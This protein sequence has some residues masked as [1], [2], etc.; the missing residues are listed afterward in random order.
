MEGNLSKARTSLLIGPKTSPTLG[1]FKQVG[2]LYR[3]ISQGGDRRLVQGSN[4]RKSRPLYSPTNGTSPVHVRNLSETSVPSGSVNH[5]KH[6]EVRSASAMEYGRGG[7]SIDS[8]LDERSKPAFTK[9]HSTASNRSQSSPLTVLQEE[10]GSASTDFASPES[11]E[12]TGLAIRVDKSRYFTNDC[13]YGLTRSQSQMS[14]RELRDQLNGLKNKIADLRTGQRAE[15]SRRNSLQNLRTPNSFTEAEEWYAG[16]AEYKSGVS[17]LS[18]NAGMGLRSN[19]DVENAFPKSPTP[20]RSPKLPR[21][22]KSPSSP[23]SPRSPSFAKTMAIDDSQS[24]V[25]PTAYFGQD[26]HSYSST[27]NPP[28]TLRAVDRDRDDQDSYIQDSLYEDAFEERS[29]E[30]DNSVAAS[31]E[32]QIYLNEVLEESLQDAEPEV[33]SIPGVYQPVEPE[34]HEDRADAFDYENFFLHSA[35]GN[36][37]QAGLHRRNISQATA[38]SRMSYE[39]SDSVETTR[40]PRTEE[41]EARFDVEGKEENVAGGERMND[42]TFIEEEEEEEEEEPPTP[43]GPQAPFAQHFRSNSTESVSSTATFATATEGDNDSRAE[44]DTV[45]SEILRWGERPSPSMVGAWPSPPA[46]MPLGVVNLT[47]GH[48]SPLS[49]N[50]LS[51]ETLTP[52]SVGPPPTPPAS[53]PLQ[54]QEEDLPEEEEEISDSSS[55]Q[56]PANTEILISALITLANPDFKPTGAF[57]EVDKDLVVNVLRSVGAV[58]EGINASDSRGDV[59]ESRIWRRRLDVARRVLEG[60]IEV[61][62]E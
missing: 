60:E 2:G 32:E 25:V 27:P 14:T 49:M 44:S 19:K 61:E 5:S 7:R 50:V 20:P 21:S 34:R 51:A 11:S 39:S 37:S 29:D 6:P 12:N 35:L 23:R 15:R 48:T 52:H 42:S 58:C 40:A 28:P 59:Y 33:P 36:Y 26:L 22:P 24:G 30:V 45:P 62:D 47:N 10:E 1:D 55:H 13:G 38:E 43:T 9:D 3:S 31:Q 46:S 53:S 4:L 56:H 8:L 18:T 54:Q 16:A 57:S 41:N 17:P